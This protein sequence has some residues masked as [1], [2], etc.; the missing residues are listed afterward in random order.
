M[1]KH[2]TRGWSA[3]FVAGV[4]GAACVVLGPGA[5]TALAQGAAPKAAPRAKPEK[6]PAK[7]PAPPAPEYAKAVIAGAR[8]A[9]A[10]VSTLSY[11][12]KVTG[13]AEAS[14]TY[15]AT[16]VVR[17]ADAGGWMMY[18]KGE[19]TPSTGDA[20]TPNAF[21]IGYDGVNARAV[22]ASEKIVFE[23]AVL[24]MEDL[25][26]FLGSQHARPVVAWELLSEEPFGKDG[27]KALFEGRETI[28]GELCDVVLV[29]DPKAPAVP[30]KAD[31]APK[32]GPKTGP[33]KD[34]AIA[35]TGVRY[36]F[37]R[38]DRLPR[39]I[40]R[41]N[42]GTA[43]VVELT[44]VATDGEAANAV[45]ALPVPQGYR[46]RDPEAAKT[47]EAGGGGKKILGDPENRAGRKAGPLAV[48]DDAPAFDLKD[49]AGKPVRLADMQGKVVVLDFW[50]TWCGWCVK[51]MPM[52]EKVHKQYKGKGVEIIG[53]NI[54]ND[55]RADPAGFMRRNR[56]TYTLALNAERATQDYRVTGYP[57]LFVIDQQGKV[58]SVHRGYSDDLDTKLSE[59]IERLLAKK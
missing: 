19:A 33:R 55:P 17:K 49:P 26:S 11:E 53:M 3:A 21:E 43:Q 16:V 13:G 59:D 28:A 54:E 15:A 32:T 48:G 57:M 25:Q 58:A 27:D 4:I 56:Y 37:A 23:K 42:A 40:E 36:A 52:I 30:A 41:F 39:R 45:F 31:P 18:V 24:E 29:P 5:G 46:I 35:P 10:T 44:K 14:P 7:A 22:R 8:E 38:S 9:L 2:T 34:A 1:S 6:A 20:P 51:A 47:R 12:A 50:G